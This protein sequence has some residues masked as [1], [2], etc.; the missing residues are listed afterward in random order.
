MAFT[1]V[2]VG[3]ASTPIPGHEL[4]GVDRRAD[5]V[6]LIRG[7]AA[8][9]VSRSHGDVSRTGAT[10]ATIGGARNVPQA[11]SSLDAGGALY[12]D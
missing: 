2:W 6:L 3:S 12:I 8:E 4:S 7:G 5:G 11:P 10:H 1:E 9:P